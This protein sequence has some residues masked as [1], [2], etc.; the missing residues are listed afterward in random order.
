MFYYKREIDI[1]YIKYLFTER[2]YQF[3]TKNISVIDN[4]N[5]VGGFDNVIQN[6][7]II[8]LD[9]GDVYST[10]YK[11]NGKLHKNV[12]DVL[13]EKSL[14]EFEFPF[15]K[16]D[17]DIP[18]KESV[19]IFASNVIRKS[20]KLMEFIF[21]LGKK[22]YT[23]HNDKNYHSGDIVVDVNNISLESTYYKRFNDAYN[24][25]IM[26]RFYALSPNDENGNDRKDLVL[27]NEYNIMAKGVHAN[28]NFDR[29]ADDN[30]QELNF[31][32]VSD[33]VFSVLTEL[34]MKYPT[35]HN[36]DIVVLCDAE[37]F[38]KNTFFNEHMNKAN[39][40]IVPN[41]YNEIKGTNIGIVPLTNVKFPVFNVQRKFIEKDCRSDDY[42]DY[43]CS[44]VTYKNNLHA[45]KTKINDEAFKLKWS[46]GK[47]DS[48]LCDAKVS[49]MRGLGI[50]DPRLMTCIF[51]K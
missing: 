15:D 34:N 48:V 12:F 42:M 18:L 20:D 28:I 25:Y 46:E 16:I 24:K 11:E 41:K 2:Y 1:Q 49:F 8:S 13:E 6:K 37:V 32:Q 51:H 3:I 26:D 44:I 21:P 10:P 5:I 40:I 30:I 38:N 27:D 19:D 7:N 4:R 45:I 9:G 22:D 31:G 17:M 39:K 47:V 43:N 29:Q 50:Q 33:A 35:F 14:R 23:L 36:D